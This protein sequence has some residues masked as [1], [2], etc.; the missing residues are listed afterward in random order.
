MLRRECEADLVEKMGKVMTKSIGFTNIINGSDSN[1]KNHTLVQYTRQMFPLHVLTGN[2]HPLISRRCYK[3]ISIFYEVSAK[4]A[5][6][7]IH[8]FFN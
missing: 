2:M 3:L 7:L 8:S 4:F 6:G 1:T 5:T